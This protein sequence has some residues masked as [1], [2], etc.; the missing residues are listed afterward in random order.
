MEDSVGMTGL[1]QTHPFIIGVG[2]DP[3]GEAPQFSVDRLS[4]SLFC[5]NSPAQTHHNTAK[6][7]NCLIALF[8]S[9]FS[10][11]KAASFMRKLSTNL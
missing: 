10:P 7:S 2:K 3:S 8:M 5:A 6:V 9:I 4:E 11:F 1:E